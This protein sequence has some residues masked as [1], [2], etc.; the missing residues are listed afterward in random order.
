VS[1]DRQVSVEQDLLVSILSKIGEH[2]GALEI[3]LTSITFLLNWS[4]L[5]RP[6][7]KKD[8]LSIAPQETG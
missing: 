8:K 7:D 5:V 6:N 1:R 2:N 3:F 4:Q